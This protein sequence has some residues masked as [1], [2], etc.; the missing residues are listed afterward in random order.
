LRVVVG[1]AAHQRSALGECVEKELAVPFSVIRILGF[2]NRDELH[3]DQH[4]ALVKI[5]ATKRSTRR[6]G[7][8]WKERD[9]R[10]PTST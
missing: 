2:S 7:H 1:P 9:C 8:S 5:L 4:R 10:W 3:R 6:P